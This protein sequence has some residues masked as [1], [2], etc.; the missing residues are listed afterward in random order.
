[1]NCFVPQAALQAPL[2]EDKNKDQFSPEFKAH[3]VIIHIGSSF[4]IMSC[5]LVAGF[6]INLCAQLQNIQF[7]CSLLM[8]YAQR[9]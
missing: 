2:E 9:Y 8:A 3:I 7:M 4:L 1:M 5:N 6:W